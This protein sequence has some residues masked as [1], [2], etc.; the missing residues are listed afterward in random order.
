[1]PAYTLHRVHERPERVRKIE[2]VIDR[3]Q[4]RFAR[5]TI[6]EFQRT[7]ARLDLVGRRER[8]R[9]LGRLPGGRADSAPHCFLN[10]RL[11]FPYILSL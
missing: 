11:R 8:V 2:V 10:E 1:L 6:F 9:D 4:G 3:L 7:D 5:G